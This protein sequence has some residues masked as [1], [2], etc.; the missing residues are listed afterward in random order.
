MNSHAQVYD[1]IEFE[2]KNKMVLRRPPQI[3]AM[4]WKP[5]R[6]VRHIRHSSKNKHHEFLISI[7]HR[8]DCALHSNSHVFRALCARGAAGE[9]QRKLH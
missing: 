9:W 3:N 5:P 4:E 7:L 1:V 2:K 6:H 8:R